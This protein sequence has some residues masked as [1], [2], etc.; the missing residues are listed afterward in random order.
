MY[1]GGSIKNAA[2]ARLPCV[3]TAVCFCG[4]SLSSQAE[5][6]AARE[7]S[8]GQESELAQK[9]A[10]VECQLG[11][12]REQLATAQAAVKAVEE[13]A[14]QEQS[15]VCYLSQAGTLCSGAFQM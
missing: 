4:T 9:L 3:P 2:C 7:A 8:A 11:E 15:Q 10:A 1:P 6:Q 12:A 5:L 13:Q 14:T